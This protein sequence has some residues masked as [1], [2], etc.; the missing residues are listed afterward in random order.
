MAWS[1]R[2]TGATPSPEPWPPSRYHVHA[3]HLA[4]TRQSALAVSTTWGEFMLHLSAKTLPTLPPDVPGPRC[5]RDHLRLGIVH[6]GS[7]A[8]TAHQAN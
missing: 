8:S 2:S 7:A 5:D 4:T 3:A 1:C 6:V